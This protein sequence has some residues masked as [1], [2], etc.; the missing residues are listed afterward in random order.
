MHGAKVYMAARSAERAN[1]AIERLSNEKALDKG[2]VHLLRLD[3]SVIKN[4]IEAAEEFMKKEQRLDLLSTFGLRFVKHVLNAS[5]VNNAGLLAQFDASMTPEGVVVPS[6]TNHFGHFAL[7][8]TLL[9]LLKA[10]AAKP[11]S[12][13]RIINVRFPVNGFLRVYL[14]SPS[15]EWFWFHPYA[16]GHT[17]A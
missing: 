4:V 11:N 14:Q 10:T 5:L 3:L 6:A 16:T 8:T 15:V 9:P 12:D 13:V 2:S 7:T 1:Q 17:K